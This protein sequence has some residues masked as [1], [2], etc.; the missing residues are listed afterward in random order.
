MNEP[1]TQRELGPVLSAIA[2]MQDHLRVMRADMH[3]LTGDVQV[4]AAEVCI[5]QAKTDERL[6]AIEDKLDKRSRTLEDKLEIGLKTLGDKVD[7]LRSDQ[8]AQK[9]VD[10]RI[11]TSMLALLAGLISVGVCLGR[12][13][14]IEPRS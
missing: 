2:E 7:D 11:W 12:L 5:N 3:T 13:V 8:S 10:G 14:L 6:Q 9:A 1:A 4:L